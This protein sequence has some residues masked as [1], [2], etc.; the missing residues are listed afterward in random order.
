MRGRYLLSNKKVEAASHSFKMSC[1]HGPNI[2]ERG[3]AARRPRR[4]NVVLRRSRTASR[5]SCGLRPKT[6]PVRTATLVPLPPVVQGKKDEGE[7]P[8][9]S[10]SKEQGL[11][12][13]VTWRI[14]GSHREYFEYSEPRPMTHG[15]VQGTYAEEH[16]SSISSVPVHLSW[17][18]RC[19][20]GLTAMRPPRP[21]GERELA[22]EPGLARARNF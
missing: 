11:P 4:I 10:R 20:E 19:T 5:V 14:K 8:C 16:V 21:I 9:D 22:C 2:Y 15:Q 18:P 1:G 3:S 17:G 12:R 6:P 13:G 7:D